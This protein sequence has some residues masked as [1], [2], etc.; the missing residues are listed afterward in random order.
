MRSYGDAVLRGVE[1]PSGAGAGIS[2]TP[3]TDTRTMSDIRSGNSHSL[4]NECNVL[5]SSSMIGC[6]CC[7][8]VVAAV[9]VVSHAYVNGAGSTALVGTASAAFVARDVAGVTGT[10]LS[11]DYRRSRIVWFA[12]DDGRYE[13]ASLL[14]QPSVKKLTIDSDGFDEEVNVVTSSSVWL[15]SLNH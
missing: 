13:L 7:C 1:L 10:P 5:T 6:C 15:T 11:F 2:A 9:V 14:S 4:S 3:T 8:F 12:F